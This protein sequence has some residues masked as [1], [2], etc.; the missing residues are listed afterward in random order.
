[1]ARLH[2]T[3]T[4]YYFPTPMLPGP[5]ETEHDVIWK[6]ILAIETM[7]MIEASRRSPET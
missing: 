4:F 2:L 5:D 7:I 3:S 1:M 6:V